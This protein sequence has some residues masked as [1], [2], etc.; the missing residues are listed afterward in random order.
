MVS[1]VRKSRSFSEIPGNPTHGRCLVLLT[2]LPLISCADC[3]A[4]IVLPLIVLR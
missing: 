4:L 1:A 3:L 2:I